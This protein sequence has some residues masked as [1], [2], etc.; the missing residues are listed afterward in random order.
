MFDINEK[1]DFLEAQGFLYK[2]PKI[3]A[4][5]LLVT[6]TNGVLRGKRVHRDAL[7][8]VYQEGVCLPGSLFG[9]NITGEIVET[10]DL[11]FDQDDADCIC[12]PLTGTLKPAPWHPSPIG[13]VLMNMFEEDGRPFFADPRH[14]MSTVVDR[15]SDLGL[16][17]VVA[18][19]LEF[20]LIDRQRTAA[21]G[22]QPPLSP[23]TGERELTTQVYGI[24]E[25]DD[26]DGILDGIAK[27][28]EMQGIYADTAM[29]GYAPGQY[30]INL[31]HQ[32]DSLTACDHAVMLKRLIKGVALRHAMEAT[33]MAKPYSDLP[34]NGMHIHISLIDES[35]QNVFQDEVDT[36]GSRIMRHAVGGLLETMAEA[37]VLFAPNVN[38]FRRFVADSFAPLTPVWGDNNRTTALRIPS[39]PQA[40]RRIEHRVA[41]ADANPYLVLAALLAGIHQGL[42]RKIESPPPTTGNAYVQYR[43]GL[44]K[45]LIEAL[46]VF[47]RSDFASCYLGEEFRRVFVANKNAEMQR[48]SNYV[49]PLEHQ[50]YLRTV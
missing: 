22:P 42:S 15:F 28:A 27:A 46:S 12:W 35:G 34:G 32:P 38:S 1:A 7:T 33:F 18:V 50:W 20:H 16:T 44:P 13:Q 36:L 26:Y 17:P 49:T 11:G 8:K 39:S 47:Q 6:D 14:I 37:M 29:A 40:A 48:F 10:T 19:E 3:A 41:G 9:V 24:T 5:D 31:K 23:V 21:G 43:P 30:K 2:H 25:L 4:I 45:T